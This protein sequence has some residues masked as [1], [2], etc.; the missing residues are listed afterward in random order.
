MTRGA[1]PTQLLPHELGILISNS[2]Y[3]TFILFYARG[4]FLKFN[5]QFILRKKRDPFGSLFLLMYLLAQG[6]V[7]GLGSLLTGAH[8]QNDGGST[9]D[10]VAAGIHAGTGGEAILVDDDAALLIDLQALGG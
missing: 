6:L 7:D 9:G 4:K 5:K 10:G 2:K 1:R 3:T 8:G